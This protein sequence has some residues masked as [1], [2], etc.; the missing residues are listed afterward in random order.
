MSNWRPAL[1]PDLTGKRAIV[2]GGNSGIGRSAARELA[3]CG[4]TV[5]LACR[6]TAKAE[7][8]KAGILKA[9]PNAAVEV[10]K[11][12]LSDL[13]SV[14]AFAAQEL[15]RHVPL[16]ILVNNAGRMVNKPETTK[17]GFELTIGGNHLGHFALT[18]LLLPAILAAP[19]A[20]VV[21]ISSVAHRSGKMDFD[22]LQSTKKKYKAFAVYAQSKLANLLFGLELDRR[23]HKAGVRAASLV[24][25]PGI[26]RTG[27]VANGPGADNAIVHALA[28]AVLSVI[29]QD[30]DHGAFPT[31]YAATAPEAHGG[32]FYG[33]G[34]FQ[35]WFG[36]PV[37]AR[38]APQG[39]DEAA[40]AKLWTVSEQLT[41]VRYEALDHP[42]SDAGGW[43]AATAQTA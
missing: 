16:D 27:F 9:A 1:I 3:R 38:A 20:R 2:T 12:D 29:G 21:S 17:D 24:A 40:A 31:L 4:T 11:L 15:G 36:F 32:K 25:H 19:Y 13:A 23:F 41:G 28:D 43:V 34:G 8:A 39:L 14:R 26:S 35:E 22:D 42:R 6:D 7:T 33:P 18:G 10:A 30:A 5:V 37:E